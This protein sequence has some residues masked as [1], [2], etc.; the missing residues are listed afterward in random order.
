[1]RSEI[2]CAL[3][4]ACLGLV[5]L[6]KKQIQTQK[7]FNPEIAR[8]AVIGKPLVGQEALDDESSVAALSLYKKL[9][10]LQGVGLIRPISS[11]GIKYE[12]ERQVSHLIDYPNELDVEKSSG[13]STSF[14]VIYDTD[15][16]SVITDMAGKHIQ[17][18]NT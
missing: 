5:V 7:K 15:I 16:H 11:K 3:N 1:G 10:T 8:L 14:L 12:I 17:L 9:A 6:G 18:I 2:I 4:E 13:P